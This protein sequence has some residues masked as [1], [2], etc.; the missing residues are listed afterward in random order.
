MSKVFVV[1]SENQKIYGISEE[2]KIAKAYLKIRQLDGLEDDVLVVKMDTSFFPIMKYEHLYLEDYEDATIMTRQERKVYEELIMNTSNHDIIRWL[3]YRMKDSNLKKKDLQAFSHVID[4]L[5][6]DE[7]MT[8]TIDVM[9]NNVGKKQYYNSI[10][11]MEARASN[12][13]ETVKGE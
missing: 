6:M 7:D 3:Q 1:M 11:S 13:N 2:K 5:E 12:Y 4:I 10:D 9:I 8:S